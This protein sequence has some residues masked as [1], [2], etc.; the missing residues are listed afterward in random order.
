MEQ[1]PAGAASLPID[2]LAVVFS[3]LCAEDRARAGAVC[4]AW[5]ILAEQPDGWRALTLRVVAFGRGVQ[6]WQ[7]GL[8]A[9]EPWKGDAAKD[10]QLTGL[11]PIGPSA[12][13]AVLRQPRFA[14]LEEVALEIGAFW[15]GYVGVGHPWDASFAA[16]AAAVPPSARRLSLR[17]WDG[18]RPA[19]LGDASHW[20]LALP[21]L[22]LAAGAPGLEEVHLLH[23]P[24]ETAAPEG[25]AT[26]G[27]PASAVRHLGA[28]VDTWN[29]AE[30]LAALR[31]AFP[32]LQTVGHVWASGEASL[33][34]LAGSGVRPLALQLSSA[35]FG[36][37]GPGARAARDLGRWWRAGA[38]GQWRCAS[39]RGWGPSATPSRGDGGARGE[40]GAAGAGGGGGDG[41]EAPLLLA[42]APRRPPPSPPSRASA[43]C[44]SGPAASPPGPRLR[45]RRRPPRRLPRPP[46]G[47]PSAPAPVPE[48][49][50]RARGG[51]G[52]AAAPAALLEAD[53][54]LQAALA[55]RR[56]APP[57]PRLS[58]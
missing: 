11:R 15:G 10:L 22:R 34:A 27:G 47:R 24:V 45:A 35:R 57:R 33:R 13:A 56:P 36:P 21:S 53:A 16:L 49:S 50:R 6:D 46:R 51:A 19:N 23:G 42:G 4:R 44:A 9:Y 43:A 38:A 48:L 8:S 7:R 14:K 5:R 12:A 28:C 32:K 31:A 17:F 20:K 18:G 29:G 39:A 55:R 52:P 3:F 26:L 54:L 2:L 1:P 37:A 30:S 40:R 41:P 58:N 25:L